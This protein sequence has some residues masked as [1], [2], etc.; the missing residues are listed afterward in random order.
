MD[1]SNSG[2]HTALISLE[3][4]S[5]E[6][7]NI[8]QPLYYDGGQ[9]SEWAERSI[10]DYW[11]VLYKRRWTLAAVVIIVVAVTAI[12]SFRMTP[13]YESVGR[14]SINKENSEPLGFKDM[15]S[16]GSAD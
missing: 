2:N 11:K 10:Q 6:R 15:P 9:G 16:N 8:S 5:L 4:Q 13:L 3:R 14:I 7:H 12:A 1:S